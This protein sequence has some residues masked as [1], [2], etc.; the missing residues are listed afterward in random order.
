MMAQGPMNP[1]AAVR[2]EEGPALQELKTQEIRAIDQT[3][4]N[5]L[6]KRSHTTIAFLEAW[7]LPG[8]STAAKG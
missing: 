5:F 7:E 8:R 6:S 2:P 4:R 1:E 3:R